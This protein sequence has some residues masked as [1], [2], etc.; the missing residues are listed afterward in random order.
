MK[1]AA[2]QIK[3]EDKIAPECVCIYLYVYVYVLYMCM[4]N[5]YE[6]SS[7]KGAI[8]KSLRPIVYEHEYVS[9]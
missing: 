8:V 2:G 9:L 4:P 7:E 1:P 3:N 5:L 6:E